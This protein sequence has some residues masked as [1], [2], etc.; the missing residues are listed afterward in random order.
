MNSKILFTSLSLLFVAS[1]S[2]NAQ[3]LENNAE[4]AVQPE[5]A[6]CTPPTSTPIIPDG[7]VASKDELLAAQSAVKSFQEINLNYLSC[8]DQKK[9]GLDPES[10]IDALEIEKLDAAVSA[11]IGMEEKMAEEFNTARKYFME[12]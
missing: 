7:N 11:A 6:V 5:I 4:E 8:L 12:R 10:D 1:A 2:L 3:E 9:V